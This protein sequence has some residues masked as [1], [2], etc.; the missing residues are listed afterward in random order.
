MPGCYAARTARVRNLS[1]LSPPAHPPPPMP[2]RHAATALV[3]T[4]TPLAARPAHDLFL[5]LNS[6]VL[7]A[8]AARV[9]VPV[10]DGTFT[11]RA[12]GV[13]ADRVAGIALVGP[14][15][16]RAFTAD[17]WEAGRDGA[18]VT[19]ALG[20]PGTYVVG[21]TTRPRTVTVA[22]AAFAAYLRDEGLGAVLAARRASGDADRPARERYAN[23]VK[24]VFQ[25]GAAQTS[26]AD[27]VLG[28]AAELVPIGNPYA[29]AVGDTLVLRALVDGRPAP[30]Q[31]ALAGGT[32][33]RGATIAARRLRADD[34]GLVRVPLVAPGRWYAKFTYVRRLDDDRTADYESRRAT[35]TFGVRE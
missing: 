27:A 25:K 17:A 4:A 33:P 10:L 6:Y 2:L 26:A 11:A 20:A 5:A 12:T 32:R 22:P 30:G 28:H 19:V 24:A 1:S 31:V 7:P 9:R 8:S 15:G 35:I 14:G 23:H 16:P 29:L 3:L 21:A 13:T 18:F 34:A